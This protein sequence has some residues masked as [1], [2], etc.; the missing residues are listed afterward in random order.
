MRKN[1]FR[2]MC[3]GK[4]ILMLGRHK[5]NWNDKIAERTIVMRYMQVCAG[6]CIAVKFLIVKNA[7]NFFCYRRDKENRKKKNRQIQ[8]Q[9]VDHVANISNQF[10]FFLYLMF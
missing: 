9:P 10:N 5:N 7:V 1:I 2:K 8:F 6:K 3:Q 4:I